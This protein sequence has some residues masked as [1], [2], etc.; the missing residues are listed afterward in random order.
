MGGIET[1]VREE[2]VDVLLEAANFD[3]INTRRTAAS[4]KLKTEASYRFERGIRADLVPR[5]LR[6]ATQLILE[7]AGG[8]VASGIV[9]Q[10]PGRKDPIILTLT[11]SR[12]EQVIGTTFDLNEVLCVLNSLG[13]DQVVD[14]LSE[15]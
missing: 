5:A 6:R 9:D 15:G 3:P 13:F 4:S 8:K 11:S 12:I 14:G 1:E 7:V 2:T 10:Y